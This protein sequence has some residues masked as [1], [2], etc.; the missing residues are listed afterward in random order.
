[1]QARYISPLGG[2]TYKIKASTFV[3]RPRHVVLSNLTQDG[4]TSTRKGASEVASSGHS[5]S[6]SAD[7]IMNLVL[8][9]C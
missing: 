7:H 5:T 3:C 6:A 8:D 1:M 2:A 4:L 9:N